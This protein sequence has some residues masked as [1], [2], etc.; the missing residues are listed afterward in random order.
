M[1]RGDIGVGLMGLGV[2][3]SGVAD[4]LDKK[5]EVIAHLVGCPVTL[6]GILVRDVSKKRLMAVDTSLVTTDADNI[7]GDPDIVIVVEVMGGENPSLE[8]IRRALEN[9]KHVVTANKEIMAKHGLE[10]L[11][12]AQER[13]LDVCYEASVG[14]G[15]PL[16]APFRKDLLANRIG[17]VY[18][19][20]NGTTNHIL[21]QMAKG[22]LDLPTALTEAIER[23]Y[24]EP[25][26]SDDLSGRDAAYKLAILSTLAFH[27]QVQPEDV[28]CEGILGLGWRDF[29]YAQELGYAIKLL[30]ISREE[31]G[32]VQ[33]R[34]H[35]TLLPQDHILAKVNGVYNA[36][37]VEG[38]LVG[39]VLFYGRGAGSQPTSSAVVADIIDL[40]RNIRMGISNRPSLHLEEGKTL[41]PMAQVQ[42]RYYLRLGVDD[43]PGVL[44]QM[45]KVLGDNAISIAS[46]IQ[47]GRD[48]EE[49]R[50][51]VVI[52]THRVQEAAM[53]RA[54]EELERLP[55][56]KEVG[57]FLRVEDI[58]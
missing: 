17:A 35:P 54:L 11:T 21:S 32:S 48:E 22:G 52:L 9:G 44:A 45:A 43:R 16:I 25:D 57:S 5:R 46:V 40:A 50:A 13:G 18:A 29:K 36:V 55:C 8:Y 39:R 24:A 49:Q 31:D 30:A 53:Q 58:S 10:L 14:G 41:M 28:Y 15:I 4:I 23:G 42:T 2:V 12:L 3:G 19:I 1:T 47:K 26:P 27:I 51:E 6:K 38:D 33:A 20:I 34:V 37:Q 56:V 7:T